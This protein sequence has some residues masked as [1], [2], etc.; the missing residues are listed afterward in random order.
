MKPMKLHSHDRRVAFTMTD[1]I[2]LL[3]VVAL[4]VALVLPALGR[5]KA[6][7]RKISCTCNLKQVGL[8]FRLFATDH[9]D[10]FPM[11]VST[12]KGGSKEFTNAA[13]LFRHYQSMSNELS[14]PKVLACPADT[15]RPAPSFTNLMNLNVSYFVALDS[16]ETMPQTLLGGDRNLTLNGIQVPPGLLVLNTNS[17]LGWSATMHNGSGNAALGDGSVQPFTPARLQDQVSSMET[18]TNRLLI[19]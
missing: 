12:N 1:L 8:S 5:A 16:D 19:P 7:S 3:A 17:V 11:N 4:L 10:A 15:R 13:E 18:A 2:V 6:K 14:T 9:S